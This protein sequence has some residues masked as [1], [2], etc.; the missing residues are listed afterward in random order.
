[1]KVFN[2]WCAG[3]L[4]EM[5]WR[6]SIP[7]VILLLV[8]SVATLAAAEPLPLEESKGEPLS[9][10]DDTSLDTRTYANMHLHWKFDICW[11]R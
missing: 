11:L 10:G 7:S 4:A 1:M 5:M 2:D 6:G 9:L 3:K 8:F